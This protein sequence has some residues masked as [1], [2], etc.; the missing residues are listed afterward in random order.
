VSLSQLN[1]NAL[2][3]IPTKS[4]KQHLLEFKQGKKK[5]ENPNQGIFQ[6]V[7]SDHLCI[8]RS[9]TFISIFKNIVEEPYNFY[10]FHIVLWHLPSFGIICIREKNI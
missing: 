10:F 4:S 5:V 9:K 6:F 7:K 3:F 8:T 1:Y 2:I